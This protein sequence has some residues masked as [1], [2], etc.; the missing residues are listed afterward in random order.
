MTFIF[1]SEWRLYDIKNALEGKKKINDK[2][3][4]R[5]AR[6]MNVWLSIGNNVHFLYRLIEN[7]N[8]FTDWKLMFVDYG[9]NITFIIHSEWRLYDIKNALEEK[10]KI[11][12]K[13]WRRIARKM[14]VRWLSIGNNVHF[15]YRLCKWR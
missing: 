3:W 10:K 2:T 1:H 4:R 5:I 14:N 13:T 15:P 7:K 12:D 9:S 11:N 8:L 6:K